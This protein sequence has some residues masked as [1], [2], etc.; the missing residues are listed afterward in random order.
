MEKFKEKEAEERNASGIAPEVTEFDQAM[1]GIIGRME[2]A[3]KTY[4][5]I[6]QKKKEKD[7]ESADEMRRQSLV[8]FAETKKRK[9]GENENGKPPKHTRATRIATMSYLKESAEK[10]T[11]MKQLE[12]DMQQKQLIQHKEEQ[13]NMMRL[14][15]QQFEQQKQERQQQLLQQQQ[16]QA[17]MLQ[18]QQQQSQMQ[19]QQVQAFM[20]FMQKLIEK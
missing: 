7:R 1:H 2:E 13:N 5:K 17:V 3:E 19:Q 10:M 20:A 18:A 15:Q 9:A 12:Y 11:T 8:T 6:T 4:H 14:L 16:L